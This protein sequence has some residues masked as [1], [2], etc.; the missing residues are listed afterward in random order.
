[1]TAEM[2]RAVNDG[3][4]LLVIPPEA[5]DVLRGA[6]KRAGVKVDLGTRPYK[7]KLFTA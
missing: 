6:L 1:M 5:F 3:Q 2:A 7:A 4:V